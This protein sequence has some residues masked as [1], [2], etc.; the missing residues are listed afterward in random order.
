MS[1]AQMWSSSCSSNTSTLS[2]CGQQSAVPMQE[3]W[4]G[5]TTLDQTYRA[6]DAVPEGACSS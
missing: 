1:L 6:Q 4:N 3:G 2:L 5:V